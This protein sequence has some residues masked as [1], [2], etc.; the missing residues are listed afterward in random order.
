MSAPAVVHSPR[1]PSTQL[2]RPQRTTLLLLAS[3][4][5]TSLAGAST[6]TPLYARYQAEWG[7]TPITTTVVFGVY[8]VSVLAALLS[9]G[10]L[11]DHV[12]RRPVLAAA[13]AAQATAMLV[14]VTAGSVPA[15]LIARVL[16]GLGTGAAAGAVGAGLLDIDRARGTLAN[17]VSPSTGTAVGVITSGLVVQYLP[18]PARLIYLLLFALFM[19]QAVG[20]L[21]MA[22]TVGR[23]PGG[24]HSMLPR[25]AFPRPVRRAMLSAGPV[26]FAIWALAGLYGSLI[27]AI[28]RRLVG[29]TSAL[30]GGL[31]LFLLAA[32]SVLA[33]LALRGVAAQTVMLIG[34]LALAS[35]VALTLVAV[36]AS[37]PVGFFAGTVVA[38]A[39]FGSG[40]QAS[41]RTVLPLVAPH[42][43]AG[44]VSLLYVVSYLG[45]GLPAVLAGVL[46]VH[47]GGLVQTTYEYG[48]AII[49]LA[50]FA[51]ISSRRRHAPAP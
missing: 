48:L 19:V 32:A 20:V 28:V 9:F 8:A 11:S 38:G 23:S 33:V 34:T 26:L 30:Y 40:F 13:V 14:F 1:P 37:W 31:G 39:G 2:D 47:A 41:M 29:S 35:G 5:V 10:E 12:G 15:L 46:V 4:T 50:G 17:A 21:L 6:P 27:P 43:R 22:E 49:G 16:Q 7:F 3:I 45:M 24:W 44:V 42:Q 51:A 36:A 18:H 25:L